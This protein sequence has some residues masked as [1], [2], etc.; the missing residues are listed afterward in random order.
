[1]KRLEGGPMR[2]RETRF[3]IAGIIVLVMGTFAHAHWNEK[4]AQNSREVRDW[5]KAQKMNPATKERLHKQ[6]NGCCENGDVFRTQ[7]RLNKTN[8]DDEWWYEKD[9]KS[10]QVPPDTIHWGQH[11]PDGQP[12]LFIYAVTGEELCFYPGEEGG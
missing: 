2:R 1:M 3:V 8:G 12:T 11:A 7:F 6:W 10:K 9:G 4:Y 5:F